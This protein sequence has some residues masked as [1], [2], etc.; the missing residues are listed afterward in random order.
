MVTAPPCVS[1][2]FSGRPRVDDECLT[3]KESQLSQ[4]AKR[5]ARMRRTAVRKS[6]KASGDIIQFLTKGTPWNVNADIFVPRA[7]DQQLVQ[8]SWET[9]QFTLEAKDID[10][11]IA[12]RATTVPSGADV[13]QTL[14]RGFARVPN[15]CIRA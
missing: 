10:D 15:N 4:S 8:G 11:G 2:D 14:P 5:R 12:S 1:S 9:L 6:V 13:G 7:V 3:Y